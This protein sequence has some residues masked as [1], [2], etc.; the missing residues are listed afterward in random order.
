[1]RNIVIAGGTGFLGSCLIDHYA[2]TDTQ[3]F[4]LTRGKSCVRGNTHYITWDGK[5]KGPWTQVL[6]HADVLINLNGKSVDCRYTEENKQLIYSTRLDA[7]AILGKAIQSSPHPPKLWINAASATI[8][9]HSLDKEMDEY[10]GEIGS[11][12]SV[13][14][15][16]QWEHT[17]N[18]IETSQTRKIII[19]TSIVLGKKGGAL[20]PLKRLAKLGMGGEQGPGNQY[21]SWLHE[22]DFVNIIDFLI[23]NVTTEGIYNLVSPRPVT[24]QHIMRAIRSA[25]GIPFGF[26]I[27]ALLLKFGAF[28]INT[29]T[30]L[31]LKSRR[32]VPKRLLDAGYNFEFDRIESALNQLCR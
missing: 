30:E 12:F 14:V 6:E 22:N 8:Y 27:P 32:V 10:T 28:L 4:I 13:D 20:K 2:E 1:M 26:P 29:E 21:F 3:L 9:R 16:Q 23:N 24:N 17:F 25:V 15:C 19:R 18:S 31:I 11:G 7:T 5:T